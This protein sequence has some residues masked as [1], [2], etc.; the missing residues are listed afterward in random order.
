MRRLILLGLILVLFCN[1]AHAGFGGFLQANTAVDVIVGP[2]IDDTDGKT[3]ET[4]LTITQVECRISKNGANTIQKNE[5]TSLTHDELGNY[6]CKF[7]TTDTNTEGIL[8]LMIH[9][10]GALA[11]KV[12]YQVLAQAAYISLMTAKDTGYIG[13]DV[14]E[15]DGTDQTPNDMS[16]DI[17]EILTDTGTTIPGTITTAQNDL[18]TITGGVGV[19]LDADAITAAKIADD[20]FSA[21]HFATNSLTNDA[22]ATSWVTEIWSIQMTDMAAGNPSITATANIVLNWL[23]EAWRNGYRTDGTNSEIVLYKDDGTTPLVE[24][25]IAD[26]GTDFTRQEFGAPD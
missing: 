15:V 13:V 2:F 19:V 4:G 18:D 12:E 10:S 16:G 8:T 24:A 11:V 14:E 21:E 7:D 3:A 9:E 6:V 22:L 23:Y 20:A 25:D 5:V 1:T 26:D 17:D